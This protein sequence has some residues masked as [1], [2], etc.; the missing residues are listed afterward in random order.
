MPA[1]RP[2]RKA[3]Q[4][5]ARQTVDTLLEAAARVLLDRG[6]ASATTNRIAARAGVSIGTLYEYFANKEELFR[7]LIGRELDAIVRAVES[8]P[9]QPNDPLDETLGRVI[10]AAMGAM[11][12]GPELVRRLEQVPQAS[13]RTQL[14]S[15]RARVVQLV[16]QI[17]ECHRDELQ[18]ADLELAAFLIVSAAEG[19]GSN[20]TREQ[21][22]APLA[23][24]LAALVRVYL[25]AD[26]APRAGSPG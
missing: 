5:R 14:A 24:E 17:L 20:A 6:Y 21:F 22:G 12:Y 4:E 23:A 13:F 16:R 1:S 25:T 9:R 15:A 10:G 3:Q 2:R 18:V 26:R 7:A 19:I 8:V 11:H